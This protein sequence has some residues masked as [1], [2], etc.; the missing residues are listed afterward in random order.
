M[1]IIKATEPKQISIINNLAE[2]IWHEHFTP[3]IGQQQVLYML[4]KFQ[5]AT[6]I[7][8]QI[9]NG[10][11]YFLFKNQ[12]GY[13]GYMA[14]SITPNSLFLSKLYILSTQRRKGHA[15]QALEYLEPLAIQNNA[16]N[17]LLTVNKHNAVAI[18]AYEKLGFTISNT[19]IK[20]IGN[21]FVMDDYEMIKKVCRSS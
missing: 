2:Q 13:I 11:S 4:E 7:S 14:I 16:S 20:D 9:A 8:Q 1:D 15:Q 19:V 12:N 17:I 3:I 21:G 5:S 6:V 10:F 18:K